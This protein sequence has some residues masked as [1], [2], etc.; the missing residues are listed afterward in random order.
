M[1]SYGVLSRAGVEVSGYQGS[2][3]QRRAWGICL[4]VQGVGLGLLQTL[5]R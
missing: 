2:A 4:E 1:Q 5:G 3:M